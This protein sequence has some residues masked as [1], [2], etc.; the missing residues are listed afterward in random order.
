MRNEY[1]SQIFSSSPWSADTWR[2]CPIF[3]GG[4]STSESGAA[5]NVPSLMESVGYFGAAA[6]VALLATTGLWAVTS[7]EAEWWDGPAKSRYAIIFGLLVGVA[8]WGSRLR[9]NTMHQ[10]NN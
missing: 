4:A 1:L 2:D 8:M 10:T 7:R 6:L 9:C 3:F 5:F